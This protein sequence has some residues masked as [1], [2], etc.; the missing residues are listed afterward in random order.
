MRIYGL[1]LFCLV[2]ACGKAIGQNSTG[3]INKTPDNPIMGLP[4]ASSFVKFL[5]HSPGAYNGVPEVSV[6]LYELKDGMVSVP[7]ELRYNASGVKVSEEASTVGL[8]WNLNVGGMIVMNVVGDWDTPDV[9]YENVIKAINPK[10]PVFL[11][12]NYEYTK[13]AKD[14]FHSGNFW[15]T[16]AGRLNPDVY[17]FNC[18][19]ASGKFFIDYRDNSIHII[20]RSQ[21]LL[22]E[23][24]GLDTYSLTLPNGVKHKFE[25]RGMIGI[26][27]QTQFMSINYLLTQTIYPNGQKVNYEYGQFSYK[28][29]MENVNFHTNYETKGGGAVG[30]TYKDNVYS[31]SIDGTE[32]YLK[33]ITTDNYEVSFNVLDR[34]DILRGKRIGGLTVRS[35]AGDFSKTFQFSQ[36]YFIAD[37]APHVFH[38]SVSDDTSRKRLRLDGV[39][40]VANGKKCN[41]YSFD[42]DGTPPDKY[43]YA[44]DYWGY[45][46]GNM[47]S[48]TF[49][50]DLK[51]MTSA[52]NIQEVYNLKSIYEDRHFKEY[53]DRSYNF[54][55]CKLGIL[56]GMTTPTGGYI[57]Y[58]YEPNLYYGRYYDQGRSYTLTVRDL[59]D[60]SADE[61]NGRGKIWLS[62]D[63]TL[64]LSMK[65]CSGILSWYDLAYTGD[66]TFKIVK[67][68]KEGDKGEVVFSY[69]FSG[70]IRDAWHNGESGGTK[71][72]KKTLNLEGSHANEPYIYEFVADIPDKLG[73]Q[74]NSMSKHVSIDINATYSEKATM[75]E[76]YLKGCG[77]R[78]KSIKSYD[79]KGESKAQLTTNYIYQN[80]I[81]HDQIQFLRLVP[82]AVY[83][84]KVTEGSHY[85]DEIQL[86]N[87]LEINGNNY[88]SNPYG[89]LSGVGYTNVESHTF[90]KN[91]SLIGTTQYEFRN[92]SPQYANFSVRLDEPDNGQLLSKNFY[93]GKG[94]LLN[95]EQYT[96]KVVPTDCYFGLNI[97]D[98]LNIYLDM[99]SYGGGTSPVPASETDQSYTDRTVILQ[100]RLNAYDITMSS[101]ATY[102]DGVTTTEKYTYDGATLLLKNKDVSLGQGKNLS[103]GYL[104]PN[105]FKFEPY[106]SLASANR[107]A[108]PV[109]EKV[110]MEGNLL[111]SAL[112]TY[113]KTVDGLILP[114]SYYK[115][116]LNGMSGN[117]TTFSSTGPNGNVYK[118]AQVQYVKYD[119]Y[120]NIQEIKERGTSTVYLWAYGHQ[121]PVMKIE[122]AT[123]AEVEG[124]LGADV[125][126]QLSSTSTEVSQRLSSC[127]MLLSN[128]PVL[129]T[130]YKYLPQIGIVEVTAPTE[131]VTR[132]SYDGFHRLEKVINTNGNTLQEYEYH[133]LTE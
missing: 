43:T 48:T 61:R 57:S 111:E 90:D 3:L 113:G 117:P 91:D 68:V 10:S 20:N 73:N 38:R 97:I 37:N 88:I 2:F 42:Y 8:G 46:N 55:F 51:K 22:I 115:S 58:E 123:F 70:V 77:L 4:E 64:D 54:D 65:I 26:S 120:G 39:C 80:G 128:R 40:E 7:I 100:H 29:Y 1:I 132:Y 41:V 79:K 121:Y 24:E 56:V 85:H 63:M 9:A 95:S 118:K 122:G 126:K 14:A 18:P 72:I 45:Y 124:W 25:K 13:E 76:G 27:G 78:V 98:K 130:T 5:E 60:E 112:T 108:S 105:D 52:Y 17:S 110:C 35:K 74:Y 12:R 84:F 53:T 107:I 15:A 109:E 83:M 69:D 89:T 47:S 21:N 127:K 103:Y 11:Y 16:Q 32:Y 125:I 67:H 23:K 131:E 102:E 36:S 31:N 133:Q 114:N 34:E 50:P 59:N 33:K 82:S 99:Y 49:L 86:V 104:Y 81:L 106:L 44:V 94:V 116:Y 96:Y 28:S 62:S 19:E 119:K 129:V 66:Y 6:P 101:K 93:D 75:Q 92:V 71:E 30:W 87:S